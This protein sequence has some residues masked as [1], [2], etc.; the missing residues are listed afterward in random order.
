[1]L[2]SERPSPTRFES[3]IFFVFLRRCCCRWLLLLQPGK[4]AT[5]RP[6]DED[7][8]LQVRQISVEHNA[9]LGLLCRCACWFWLH[10]SCTFKKI[11]SRIMP[12]RFAWCRAASPPWACRP[13]AGNTVQAMP[14]LSTQAMSVAWAFM[15]HFSS[16][17]LQ[18]RCWC[19][20]LDARSTPVF[21]LTASSAHHLKNKSY[22]RNTDKALSHKRLQLLL[23]RHGCA[24]AAV[25]WTSTQPGVKPPSPSPLH[26]AQRAAPP[27]GTQPA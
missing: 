10:G 2:P 24:T 4:C 20:N 23:C 13:R 22:Q 15:L 21:T 6:R 16:A 18:A 5:S 25:G 8:H 11:I 17:D 1:M 26:Q 12:R 27:P 7:G 14:G 3:G 19:S 9:R